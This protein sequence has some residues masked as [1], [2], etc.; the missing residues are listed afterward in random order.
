MKISKIIVAGTLTASSLFAHG[1]WLNSFEASSHG[2][3]LVTVGL[4]TGHNPSIEDSISDR[5]TLSSFDLI[6]PKGEKIALQKPQKG[7]KEIYNK[8]N[9]SIVQSNLA[10][11]KV[12]F[13]KESPEGTYSAVLATQPTTFTKYL[14]TNNKE[15]FTTKSKDKIR[16]LKEIISIT[17]NTT[18]AKTYFVNKAWT[19]P[20]AIGHDLELIPTNDIAALT[21]GGT[22]TF[23]VLYQGKPLE[24]GYV[25][26]KNALKKKDNALFANVRKGKATFVLNHSGQWLFTVKNKKEVDGITVSDTATATIN[27]Q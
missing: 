6:T 27:V 5:I 7:L 21:K 24:S 11:Q 8:D 26:A 13:K 17:N 2:G 9:L 1:L 3:K 20:E 22:L 12:A 16:N 15:S 14:D 4:G 25:T 19:Q 23:Q 10:M 18:Y